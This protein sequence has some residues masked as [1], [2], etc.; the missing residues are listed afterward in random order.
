MRQNRIGFWIGWL[1]L[2][3]LMG[4]NPQTTPSPSPLTT[5]TPAAETVV[6]SPASEIIVMTVLPTATS[7]P[8][9]TPQVE[10]TPTRAASN[11]TTTSPPANTPSLVLTAIPLT[12]AEIIV[13]EANVTDKA[14]PIPT[15][16]DQG[17]QQLV[18]QAKEDLAQR[19]GLTVDQIDLIE[20]K[21]VIWP[22]KGL[23]CPKPGMVYPQVPED[24][25]LIRLKAGKHVYNYHVGLDRP[26][27]L[28]EQSTQ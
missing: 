10:L 7:Q 19:F 25:M 3:G 28:C 8:A 9:S 15:P 17:L 22:D 1:I 20:L 24:G 23:G 21:Y 13:K 4:C 27:F 14:T 6:V 5:P 12:P 11:A 26:P 18:N 2:V 16:S